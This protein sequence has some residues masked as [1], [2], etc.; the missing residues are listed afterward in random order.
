MAIFA[1]AAF[2]TTNQI[3][4]NFAIAYVNWSANQLACSKT[5]SELSR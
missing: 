3:A 1:F 4:A 5:A 2:T